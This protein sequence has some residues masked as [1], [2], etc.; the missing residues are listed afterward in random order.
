MPIVRLH[1]LSKGHQVGS[2]ELGNPEGPVCFFFHGFPGSSKQIGI[3]QLPEFFRKY[4]VIALDRSGFGDS[5]FVK[6]RI[7]TDVA[8]DVCEIA[9][10]LGIKKFHLLSVSG[11][12]PSA[13]I[14]AD[15]K[16]DRVL[17]LTTV[18]GLGPLH[19]PAVMQ[20]MPRWARFLLKMGK[21]S[22]GGAALF[23]GMVNHRIQK[24]GTLKQKSL[25][26]VFAPVDAKLMT[27]E[28]IRSGFKESMGHAFKQGPASVALEVQV[29]QQDWKISNWNFPFP[30]RIWHGLRDQLVPYQH[31]EILA[32]RIPGA[33][34][35]LLP[36][37]GHYSLPIMCIQEILQ[38]LL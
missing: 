18:C 20:A 30:V 38:P 7:I 12:T 1:Q 4:R 8:D 37:E 36:N 33:E 19:E 28:R 2:L 11:G 14:I 35:H 10:S 29:F 9:D 15:R 21:R 3:V 32:S 34:L 24:G 23:L 16:R 27:D 17:S 25:E 31:S 5:S 22:T 13:Y 26:K 6:N